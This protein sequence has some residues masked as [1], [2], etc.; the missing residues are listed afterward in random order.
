MTGTAPVTGSCRP[1]R[2]DPPAP[3]WRSRATAPWWSTSCSP[4]PVLEAALNDLGAALNDTTTGREKVADIAGVD[5]VARWSIDHAV[6]GRIAVSA[7]GR[8]AADLAAGTVRR[9]R[10]PDR[11]CRPDPRARCQTGRW[12]LRGRGLRGGGDRRG[13]LPCARAR[14]RGVPLAARGPGR[15]RRTHA[16]P[17][18]APRPDPLRLRPRDRGPDPRRPRQGL[19]RSARRDSLRARAR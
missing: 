18:H 19:A 14:G 3:T 4:T 6:D 15:A 12:Q 8:P 7:E 16:R 2:S 1:R 9:H 11:R 5:L 10:R 17:R 13:L